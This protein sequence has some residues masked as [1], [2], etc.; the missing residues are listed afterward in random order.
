MAFIK[1]KVEANAPRA[2]KAYKNPRKIK[3]GSFV[4]LPGGAG[5]IKIERSGEVIYKR[6]G[7]AAPAK[8]NPSKRKTLKR[9]AAALSKWMRAE[10]A[11]PARKRNGKRKP[12]A[13][14][15]S[16]KTTRRSK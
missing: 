6:P 16:T 14:K 1:R 3:R 11:K 13:R 9:T 10:I 8:R 5:S 7:A 4:R 15:T 12:A 2:K